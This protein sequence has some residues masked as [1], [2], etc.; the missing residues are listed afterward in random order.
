[1]TTEVRCNGEKCEETN[2]RVTSYHPK[3]FACS[4][5]MSLRLAYVKFNI[6]SSAM[7]HL[8]PGSLGSSFLLLLDH[9]IGVSAFCQFCCVPIQSSVREER[10]YAMIP[11]TAI[12]TPR[13]DLSPTERPEVAQPRA[14][15]VQV[16]K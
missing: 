8:G 4:E 6:L 13:T 10:T 2:G 7:L 9:N 12:N 1:M 14:I 3:R 11:P 16:F 5:T 15:M